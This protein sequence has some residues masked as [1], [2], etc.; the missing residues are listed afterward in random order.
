MRIPLP[1]RFNVLYTR[2]FRLYFVGQFI[3]LVGMW[4]QGFAASWVVL[5][6]LHKPAFALAAVNFAFAVPGLAFMLYGG[7]TADRYDRRRIL[8]YSNL[9]F[10]LLAFVSATLVATGAIQFW[11]IILLSLAVGAGQAFSMPAEQAMVPSLVQ[12][13]EIPQAIALNQVI[14]NGSRLLGPALA[15]VSVA[16]LGLASAYYANGLSYLAVIASLLMIRQAP[17]AAGIG[18]RATALEA[19]KEGIG[20]VTRSPLLRSLMGI[21]AATAFFVMPCLAVFSPAYVKEALDRGPGTSAV[22][23]AASGGASL[24]GAFAMLWVPAARRGAALAGCIL[25]SACALLVMS[26]TH[27]PIVATLAFGSLS[28]GMGLVFGLNATTIQQVTADAIRGRVM[29]VSGLTFG[30]VMPFATVIV[31]ASVELATIRVAYAACGILYL[32]IAGTMLLRCR[33]IGRMP[34]GIVVPVGGPEPVPA[35]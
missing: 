18:A 28:L 29:S 25:L 35:G 23:M 2:N 20:Y 13:R 21:S 22:L 19:M 14:F 4:M 10:M 34:E 11:Q 3:S 7:V 30:G 1:D 31:G 12:P 32:L 24:F 5:D 27:S 15:G 6:V 9:A 8:L 26:L 33:L 16:V 17:R